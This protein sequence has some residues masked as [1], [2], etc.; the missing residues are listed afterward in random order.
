MSD[1]GIEATC[2]MYANLIVTHPW[3]GVIR[4]TKADVRRLQRWKRQ[5]RKTRK[6]QRGWA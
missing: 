1:D 3:V 4:M 6:K 2:G 5:A